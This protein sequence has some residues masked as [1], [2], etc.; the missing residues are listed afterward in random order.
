MVLTPINT[1]FPATLPAAV[2]L[3]ALRALNLRRRPAVTA[4]ATP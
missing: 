1:M 4:L 2:T 3:I